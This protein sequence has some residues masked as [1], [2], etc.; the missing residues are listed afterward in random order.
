M[1]FTPTLLKKINN[2][3]AEQLVNA[4]WMIHMMALP[5]I[6]RGFEGLPETARA[7]EA[8]LVSAENGDLEGYRR[9]VFAHYDPLNQALDSLSQEDNPSA[10][11]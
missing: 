11:K 10:G 4:M 5:Q 1:N 2:P 6:H 3:L 9:A 7:H 8:M